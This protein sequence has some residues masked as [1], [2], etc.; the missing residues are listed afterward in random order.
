MSWQQRVGLKG[1]S[2]SSPDGLLLRLDQPT[3]AGKA[4][5]TTVHT[6]RS[7]HAL[8]VLRSNACLDRHPKGRNQTPGS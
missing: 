8:T 3:T 2:V 5:Q 6:L 7:K 1:Q 4:V